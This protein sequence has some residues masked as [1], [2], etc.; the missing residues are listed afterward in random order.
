M[1]MKKN[2]FSASLCLVALVVGTSSILRPK[3]GSYPNGS[4]VTGY[5]GGCNSCHSSG[6]GTIVLGGIPPFPNVG[7]VYPVTV[8]INQSGQVFG[9]D[10]AVPT[11]G[12][13]FSVNAGNTTVG[14]TSAKTN[15]HHGSSA[16][17]SPGIS[18][19][20]TNF[21][22]T[23]PTTPGNVTFKYAG[24]AGNNDGTSNG[25]KAVK[26]STSVRV[27]GL[28]ISIVSIGAEL[29][30]SNLVKIIWSVANQVNTKTFEIQKSF[31]GE[32]FQSVG[33]IPAAGNLSDLKTY[34]LVDRE[35]LLGGKVAYR[36]KSIDNDGAYNLSEIKS[37]EAK[38][39][40]AFVASVY[41][42]PLAIGKALGVKFY[43]AKI[44]SVSF[45]VY[46]SIGKKVL[47]K[48]DEVLPGDN[49]LTLP[50]NTLGKGQYYVVAN[51]NGTS[52]K[53]A[54]VVE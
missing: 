13:T 19:T 24:L 27:V 10:M 45:Q 15:V 26:G 21:T 12:G 23:A 36:L 33:S 17:V 40:K 42:N 29:I 50:T 44:G 39:T 41:P 51:C 49:K 28:P 8:T 54:F 43:S 46:S 22:W 20:F 7:Q 32:N 47:A 31:D 9:F 38:E 48:N 16:P 34:S 11:G 3:K 5:S 18:Y 35:P 30:E 25:D 53:I 6:T 2:L 37:I 14:V 4:Q 1:G 52:Q